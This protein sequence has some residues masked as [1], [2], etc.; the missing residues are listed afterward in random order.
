MTQLAK[1]MAAKK[2]K[3]K[4]ESKKKPTTVAKKKKLLELADLKKD[5]P[6]RT[7]KTAIAKIVSMYPMKGQNAD[8][9]HDQPLNDYASKA[10]RIYGSYV[11]EERAV[12]DYRD[13]LKPSHRA[14]LWSMS[15]L[16]LVPNASYKKSARTV[17]EAIGKYHPH[18]DAA[19][20]QAMVTIA[21]TVPPAVDGQGNWGTPID[22]AAAQRYTEARLSKFSHLFLLD[23]KYLEVVPYIQN[24]SNDDKI[25]LHLP[26][27]LPYLMFNGSIPAPAY[28]VRAG[29][30]SWSFRS[31]AKV[32]TKMLEGK[33]YTVKT[34]AK[35]LDICHAF[36]CLDASTASDYNELLETGRGRVRYKPIISV[37]EKSRTIY[38]KTFVPAKIASSDQIDKALAKIAAIPDVKGAHSAQ[39]KRNKNAGPYG[40][41]LTVECSK[42][43]SEDRL[44]EVARKVEQDMSST[45]SYALGITIRH[46]DKPND[47]R[48]MNVLDYLKAWTQYRIK[49]ESRLIAKQ[50]EQLE[51]D[52]HVQKVYLFAIKNL[53]ALLAALPKV[54]KAKDPDAT[55]AKILKIPL[56]DANIILSRQIRKLASLERED[57]E[58]VIKDLIAQIK[59][60]KKEAKDPADRAARDTK[61][62]VDKYLKNPDNGMPIDI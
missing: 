6:K 40:A 39:G 57:I 25:P 24:F 37:D 47:F 23:R 26:A 4:A 29:N 41:C 17:G 58:K 3:N 9:I 19:A 8:N 43:L 49:L 32:V 53:N 48:Y 13:G 27:L 14:I 15:G 54:L 18:G 34:L 60:L 55:L 50:L 5:K 35:D 10:L 46:S 2:A 61:A 21:N 42:S 51:R 12:A 38:V 44:Y 11:V 7:K 52:L 31:V 62:R 20:Y 16:G 56:E 36:G 22:P 45:I 30:P 28:G 1:L 59:V 33:D